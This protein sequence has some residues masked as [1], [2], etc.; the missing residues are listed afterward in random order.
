[1]KILKALADKHLHIVCFDVP[2]PADYG[3]VIDVFYRIKA[4]HELGIKIHLHCFEYGRGKQ[5]ELEQ[6]CIEVKYYK[7]NTGWKGFS[8]RELDLMKTGEPKKLY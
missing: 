3:G 1:M 2:Y 4:F 7:R 5:I 8:W 6:Y